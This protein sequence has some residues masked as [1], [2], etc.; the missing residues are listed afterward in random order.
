MHEIT[1][2]TGQFSKSTGRLARFCVSNAYY[3]HFD[4]QKR[5]QIGAAF[6]NHVR[7]VIKPLFHCQ[8]YHNYFDLVILKLIFMLKILS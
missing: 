3:R 5:A 1:V 2:L 8:Y 7:L 4:A 6:R